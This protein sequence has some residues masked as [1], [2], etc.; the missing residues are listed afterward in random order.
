MKKILTLVTAT[1]LALYAQT[2]NVSTTPEFRTALSNAASNGESDTIIL[3]DGTYKT[4]DDGGGTFI[5]LDN[6]EHNLTLMGSS[7]ENVI[8]SGD[9]Q[10]QIFNHNSTGRAPL[11]IEKLTF[12][13]GNYSAIT[14]PNYYAGGLYTDYTIEVI[15]SNFT[16]NTTISAGGGLY[17]D[18]AK[19]LN[20]VFMNNTANYDGGA[21]VA[22]DMIIINSNISNNSA[23]DEGGGI[24]AT[25][26]IIAN[27]NI[28]NNSATDEGGGIHARD[29]I[30]SNSIIKG[31]T[32]LL[33]GGIYTDYKATVSNTLF[34]ENSSAV[35]INNDENSVITNSIFIDNNSLDITGGANTKIS[36][37]N[38]YI[39]VTNVAVTSFKS[40]NIFDGVTIGFSDSGNNDYRLTSSSTLLEY[41]TDKH[42]DKFLIDDETTPYP[43]EKINLLD[44][45]MDGNTRVAGGKIDIGAYEFSTTRPTISSI[46]YTGIAK[47]FTE[48][49]FTTVYT[50]TDAR[51]ITSVEYDYMNDEAYT[52]DNIYTFRE[53]GTYT[54]NVKVTDDS[55]EF[56]IASKTII[57]IE[58]SYSEMTYEQKLKKVIDPAYYDDMI[59]LINSQSTSS[60]ADIE[61]GK[62]YVQ[63]NLEEF[64]LVTTTSISITTDSI[65]TLA[66]GWSLTSTPIEVTDLS[67]FDTA[68]IIWVYNNSTQTWRA[69]S[70]DATTKQKIIDNSDVSLLTTIPAGSGIWVQK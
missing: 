42:F 43:Y 48:L 1:T 20:S 10:H 22:R 53:A 26:V 67:I 40:N 19:I 47:E 23:T 61:I 18:D 35:Y 54:I 21:I 2:F 15:D 60:E 12:M 44:V 5:F 16:N 7:S 4:T 8:L 41:G 62:Q 46:T 27:S 49:T 13:D 34:V 45:D 14:S 69:Y 39:D 29:I 70:S 11:K 59:L 28:S 3:A 64:G 9:N 31:N 24:D 52:T 68:T 33:G 30:M 37:D 50:L 58:L 56:S 32:A 66:Q 55:G 6:E 38:N 25:H 57:V 65:N 51:N 63:D 36:L 17:S